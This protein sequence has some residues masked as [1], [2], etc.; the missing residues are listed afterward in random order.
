MSAIAFIPIHFEDDH[1]PG[2]SDGRD[3]VGFVIGKPCNVFT[4]EMEYKA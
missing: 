2:V 1:H 3:Y 4:N